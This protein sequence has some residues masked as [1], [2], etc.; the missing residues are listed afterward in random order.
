MAKDEEKP[1][2]GS[3]SLAQLSVTSEKLAEGAIVTQKIRDKNVTT[4]KLA[5]GSVTADKLAPDA[6]AAA[7]TPGMVGSTLLD[8]TIY[9]AMV[10]NGASGGTALNLIRGT[11]LGT[12][13]VSAGQ[14]FGSTRTFAGIYEV[15]FGVSFFSVPS[16][17]VTNAN[18]SA[19]L[20][21][22]VNVLSGQRFRATLRDSAGLPTDSAFCFLAV[23]PR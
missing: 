18:E 1:I 16:V 10:F 3:K 23:G 12:G 11:V 14:G 17:L 7:F 6:L 20:T 15:T 9:S 21:T 4:R 5:D 8:P 13:T 19:V 2:Y 22:S